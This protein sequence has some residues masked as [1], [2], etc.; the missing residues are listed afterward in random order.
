MVNE[1]PVSFKLYQNH[2]NPFN[3]STRINFEIP[4]KT[5]VSLVVYNLLGQ[6]AAVIA[7]K[8]YSA[9]VHSVTFDASDLANGIYF[10]TLRA[11]D[12]IDTRRMYI[13]K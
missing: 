13:I 10:Y 11:E 1:D 3:R 9:G 2:P 4:E 6:E 8:E 5:F 7:E 12:F